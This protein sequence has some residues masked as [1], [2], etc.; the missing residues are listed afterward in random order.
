MTLTI[1]TCCLPLQH[2]LDTTRPYDGIPEL[3][4]ELKA[5]GCKLAVVSNKMMATTQALVRHLFPDVDALR[6]PF[7]IFLYS[8]GVSL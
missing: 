3:L 2:S 6:Q 5:R 7:E 4:H 1:M 8:V